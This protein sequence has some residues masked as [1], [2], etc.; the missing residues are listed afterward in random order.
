M[1]KLKTLFFSLGLM[2]TCC[3]TADAE[4]ALNW[5]EYTKEGEDALQAERF[6]EAIKSFKS[7]LA[8]LQTQK[9]PDSDP[10]VRTLMLEDIPNLV[11]KLSLDK[12]NLD[13]AE[14]LAK[15]K[16][17]CTQQLYGKGTP[18]VL[19]ALQDLQTLYALQ[20][21]SSEVRSVLWQYSTTVTALREQGR[22]ADVTDV[23]QYRRQR[24]NRKLKESFELIQ[25]RFT[26]VNKAMQK[27]EDA[28][29]KGASKGVTDGESKN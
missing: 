28:L 7:A 21:K 29:R 25:K 22:D 10:A 6:G 12:K 11:E 13:R 15:A 18:L 9:V 8:D 27:P 14:E 17:I 3:S 23:E 5:R 4:Q 2:F 24:L 16:L 26:P 1:S 19:D 20:E